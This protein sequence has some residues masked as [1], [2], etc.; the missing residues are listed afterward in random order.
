MTSKNINVTIHS[1]DIR[2]VA[3]ANLSHVLNRFMSK[4]SNTVANL[5]KNM[6]TEPKEKILNDMADLISVLE[7]AIPEIA[8]IVAYVNEI[9]DL[10]T[11]IDT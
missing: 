2:R 5:G 10:P 7:G 3:D 9:E 4:Y 1:D 6:S 11:T 8:A